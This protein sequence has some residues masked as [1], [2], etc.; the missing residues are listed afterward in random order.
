MRILLLLLFLMV[1]GEGLY[2]QNQP[3]NRSTRGSSLKSSKSNS[4]LRNQ[5]PPTT[6][7]QS[8]KEGTLTSPAEAYNA[9]QQLEAVRSRTDGRPSPVEQRII[10][11]IMRERKMAPE[12]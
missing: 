11:R 5:L 1:A 7:N 4:S 10:T 6:T 2:A 9:E 3:V 12:K 8:L